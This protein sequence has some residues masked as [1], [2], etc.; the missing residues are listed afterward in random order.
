MCIAPDEGWWVGLSKREELYKMFPF[1]CRGGG[2]GV[3]DLKLRSMCYPE[4]SLTERSLKKWGR[5][6]S[7]LTRPML[8]LFLL[9]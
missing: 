1:S 8:L 7:Y 5:P 2:F 3:A 9:L 4:L 6:Q